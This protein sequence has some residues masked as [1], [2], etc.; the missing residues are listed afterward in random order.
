MAKTD[1]CSTVSI[2]KTTLL[3]MCENS[4]RFIE[5][6]RAEQTKDL[7]RRRTVYSLLPW[8]KKW[9]TNFE[10]HPGEIRWI[11]GGDVFILYEFADHIFDQINDLIQ[12]LKVETTND[13]RVSVKLLSEIKRHGGVSNEK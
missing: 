8:Y 12:A 9:F 6:R 4:V 3:E 2:D 11:S 5:M 1:C 13:V 10:T 7:Q